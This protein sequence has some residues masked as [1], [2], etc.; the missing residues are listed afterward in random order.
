MNGLLFLGSEDFQLQTGTKGKVMCHGIPGFSLIL[1]YSPKCEHCQ[2]LLPIFKNLPGSLGGCQF[3]VVNVHVNKE[4]IQLSRE[5]MAPIE[6]V[7]Y[8]MLYID[9]MPFMIYK[10]PRAAES[11]KHFILDVANNVQKKQK[12][13]MKDRAPAPKTETEVAIPA[14][15]IGRPVCGDGKVC[16]LEFGNAYTT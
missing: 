15:T 11:I 13:M 2:T 12:F 16:Y 14:Y 4:C 5:S 7:P 1:F 10:G 6:Y 8:V 3:G 9:G